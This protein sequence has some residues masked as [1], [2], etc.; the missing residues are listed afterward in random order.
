MFKWRNIIHALGLFTILYLCLHFAYYG[1]KNISDITLIIFSLISGSVL[2][3]ISALF[4][5]NKNKQYKFH[6]NFLMFAIIYII[7]L[8]LSTILFY[9]SR[10][11][12]ILEYILYYFPQMLIV[13]FMIPGIISHYLIECI[14]H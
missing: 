8:I 10:N 2:G 9:T 13:L 5:H 6:Q 14:F 7:V 11:L 4:Y 3:I 1:I 12:Y